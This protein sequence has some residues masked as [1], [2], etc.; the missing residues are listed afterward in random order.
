MSGYHKPW[1]PAED[2]MLMAEVDKRDGRTYRQIGSTF[3]DRSTDATVARI[4]MLRSGLPRTSP[5]PR[6]NNMLSCMTCGHPFRS[7]NVKKNRMCGECKKG[8]DYSYESTQVSGLGV[9]R[10]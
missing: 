6:A 7:W 4:I 8:H 10:H 2:A 9:T 5:K 1:T 3:P